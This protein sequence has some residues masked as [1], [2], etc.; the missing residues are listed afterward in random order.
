MK[1]HNE[2][3]SDLIGLSRK[4]S[5]PKLLETFEWFEFRNRFI[6]EHTICSCCKKPKREVEVEIKNHE[7]WLKEVREINAYNNKFLKWANQ[8]PNEVINQLSNDTYVG[9]KPIPSNSKTILISIQIH[10]KL[11]FKNKLPWEYDSKYIEVLCSD[12]H[13]NVHNSNVIYTFYDE[14]MLERKEN[15]NCKRC[16]GTGTLKQYLYHKNGIC[17]DC[18]GS[19]IISDEESKWLSD[20]DVIK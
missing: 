7:E 16:G 5:Y 4:D 6:N 3:I 12:C 20:E 14:E 8:N 19:G 15:K 1:T 18:G 9:Q 17:F 13:F 11:Y 10:H 2:I